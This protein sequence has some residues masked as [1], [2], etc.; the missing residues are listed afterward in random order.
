[1]K[2]ALLV[3]GV[4]FLSFLSAVI[5]LGFFSG[6]GFRYEFT[7][8]GAESA[9]FLFLCIAQKLCGMLPFITILAVI[10][11]YAFLMRHRAKIAVAAS[12]FAACLVFTVTVIIPICF[13]QVKT[14]TA[15]LNTFALHPAADR[16]LMGFINKPLFVTALTQ[17]V[18]V[19]CQDIYTIYTIHF[20]EYLLFIGSFFFCVSSFWLFCVITYWSMFNLLFMFLASGGFLLLYPLLKQNMFQAML[21]N[22]HLASNESMLGIPLTFCLIAVVLH[23]SGILAVL[24]KS[25][26]NKK[27]SAA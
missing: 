22:L 12:L 10:G 5:V 13:A 25:I 11:V 16:T 23:I 17:A 6:L 4:F 19:L 27:R 2:N 9:V 3:P 7:G 24:T 14:L 8:A 18:N 15:A 20:A 1:M 26:K 21:H